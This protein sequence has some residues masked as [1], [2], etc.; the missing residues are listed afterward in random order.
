[1][2]RATLWKIPCGNT[3]TLNLR[4]KIAAVALLQ[5][6]FVISSKADAEGA[7]FKDFPFIIHCE[8]NEIHR[9]YYL[10]K[11]DADGMAIYMSPDRQAGTITIHGSAKAIGQEASGSCVGRTL[12][13]LRSA[14]QAYEFPR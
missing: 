1:M 3:N 4:R 14:G 13:Q 6:A 2:A 10:S 7:A 5:F 11:V 12:E 9:A 8:Y